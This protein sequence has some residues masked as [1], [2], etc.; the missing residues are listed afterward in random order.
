[1]AKAATRSSTNT[2][3]VVGSLTA[4]VG[5]FTSV[6]DA[7]KLKLASFQTAG[8]NGG[9]LKFQERAQALPA[10]DRTD[11][12]PVQGSPLGSAAPAERPAPSAAPVDGEFVRKLVEEGS[13]AVVEPSEVRRGLFVGEGDARRFVDVTD[14]LAA[15]EQR[16]KLDQIEVVATVDRTAMRMRR[17]LGAHFVGATDEESSPILRLLYESLHR[18]RRV[19]VAKF[20]TGG[21]QKLGVIAPD[22]ATQT[23][24]MLQLAF[25]EDLRSAPAK[26]K[27]IQNVVVS[28]EHVQVMCDI[29]DAFGDSPDVL[30][31]LTDDAVKFRAELHARA[32]A[33]EMD[34]EVVEPVVAPQPEPS[35]ME[36]LEASLTAIAGN[37]A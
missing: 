18:T 34:V 32:A 19:A 9:A 20:T 6:Q 13:G 11:D 12:V 17:V 3:L 28:E 1:M 10:A 33:G 31:T 5:L 7:S 36:A 15:I 23:L 14:Q 22:R 21:R 37:R 26:A 4:E 16:T 35:L 29:L 30:D 24:M 2:K 8:P 25:S 27:A